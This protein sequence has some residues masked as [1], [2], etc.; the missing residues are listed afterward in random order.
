MRLTHA[1]LSSSASC[2]EALWTLC[3][4]GCMTSVGCTACAPE[5]S[6]WCNIDHLGHAVAL[7]TPCPRLHVGVRP[8]RR[9]PQAPEGTL[10]DGRR[11]PPS[12]PIAALP[13]AM[14][15]APGGP[16][17]T[18]RQLPCGMV[19]V[20][21]RSS[22][23]ELQRQIAAAMTSAAEETGNWVITGG[24][25]GRGSFPSPDQPG[26]SRRLDH[27]GM[28]IFDSLALRQRLDRRRLPPLRPR[29]RLHQRSCRSRR[30]SRSYARRTPTTPQKAST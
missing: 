11:G 19:A 28:S 2:A 23:V 14:V 5:R 18:R 25:A 21:E 26:P 6:G 30:R 29:R 7:G 20:A 4:R 16:P 17:K 24:S 9:G 22:L 12:G 15:A 13:S 10:D 3:V 1:A 27:I 8:A